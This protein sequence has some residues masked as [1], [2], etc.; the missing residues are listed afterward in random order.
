MLLFVVLFISLIVSGNSECT[1]YSLYDKTISKTGHAGA[2]YRKPF[3]L[4]L[5][6]GEDRVRT[7]QA[8][9]DFCNSKYWCVA[10]DDLSNY[11][12]INEYC[13]F[14]TDWQLLEMDKTHK[15]T[16][17]FNIF[18]CMLNEHVLIN[19]D[20]DVFRIVD[21]KDVYGN[22]PTEHVLPSNIINK[23]EGPGKFCHVLK[24]DTQV[25][26]TKTKARVYSDY[27]TT[28]PIVYN[29][30]AKNDYIDP[31]YVDMGDPNLFARRGTSIP[32]SG[33]PITGIS[34]VNHKPYDDAYDFEQ[35]TLLRNE[36]I[37]YK[38]CKLPL[39]NGNKKIISPEE[40][41]DGETYFHFITT[42]DDGSE[43]RYLSCSTSS[44]D[45]AFVCDWV[46]TPTMVWRMASFSNIF[47][48]NDCNDCG[49][50][51]KT[52]IAYD[53][54]NLDHEIGWLDR[55]HCD[56]DL[57]TN[58]DQLRI[59]YAGKK[60]QND[61]SAHCGTGH[62]RLS[63][64]HGNKDNLAD[65]HG[66]WL[67][68]RNH[69]RNFA[70]ND[71]V[72]AFVRGFYNS[73]SARLCGIEVHETRH[74]VKNCG[75]QTRYNRFELESIPK[76]IN[77]TKLYSI[78]YNTTILHCPR[79]GSNCQWVDKPDNDSKQYFKFI[80]NGISNSK[81]NKQG[82]ENSDRWL[83]NNIM[84][85]EVVN[86]FMFFIGYLRITLDT[87]VSY[88]IEAYTFGITSDPNN[89]CKYCADILK[90]FQGFELDQTY[91]LIIKH[92]GSTFAL[93]EGNVLDNT[94]YLQKINGPDY[95]RPSLVPI[96]TEDTITSNSEYHWI[97]DT[98][99]SLVDHMHMCPNGEYLHQVHCKTDQRCLHVDIACVKPMT[100]CAV[101][102]H[103]NRTFHKL[104]QEQFVNC[105]DETVVVG[106]NRSHI[107]CQKLNV[108]P[109]NPSGHMERNFP[110]IGFL[111]DKNV[112]ATYY[113]QIDSDG[114]NWIGVPYQAIRPGQ[115]HVDLWNYGETCFTKF[116]DSEFNVQGREFAVQR[117][118]LA[119]TKHGVRCSDEH[120]FISFIS[121]QYDGD[122][123]R[124]LEITCDAAPTCK[125]DGETIKITTPD[126]QVG[127]ICPFGTVLKGISCLSASEHEGHSIPCVKM[128]LE[129]AKV[130][131]D[132]HFDPGKP[133]RHE[134]KIGNALKTVLIGLGVGLPLIV[135]ASIACLCCLPDNTIISPTNVP[136]E[137]SARIREYE[138]SVPIYDTGL[139][140]RMS[141]K[142]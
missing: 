11:H 29:G 130:V 90:G 13:Q 121:C 108:V 109:Q 34:I 124:G 129:C 26:S 81:V 87:F 12:N 6:Y 7:E 49:G 140:Y 95:N 59:L 30:W 15:C 45:N 24:D 43:K 37:E 113:N 141:S 94:A 48:Y 33:Y 84:V 122:C 40:A 118:N 96:N 133:K 138:S 115:G 86:G 110:D 3:G 78:E 80:N 125:M 117:V 56:S 52:F 142:F 112:K 67:S 75:G 57:D 139:R 105:P 102:L 39:P 16:K 123:R 2:T 101:D 51:D 97:M 62:W 82:G 83:H 23:D 114:K 106:W 92:E 128:Q 76:S 127:G 135:V 74:N 55:S 50:Y 103:N 85:Y 17:Q 120:D 73:N 63:R 64:G 77:A 61:G 14:I 25:I 58:L 66:S 36:F 69:Y 9:I 70:E 71:N 116:E 53:I 99:N 134:D 44:D 79:D 131:Y 126:G 88:G 35:Y 60:N 107:A 22:N 47:R 136:V 68:R 8:C 21:I 1:Y 72:F 46:S 32:H 41:Y 5:A 28:S 31:Y 54:N 100:N 18:N 98:H 93:I 4:V 19:I 38:E 119:G 132:E 89:E 20:S 10:T 65:G 91:S 27:Y 137:E 42:L 111:T 104:K